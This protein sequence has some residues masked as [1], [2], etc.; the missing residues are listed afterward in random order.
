[1]SHKPVD[2]CYH[3]ETHRLAWIEKQG[4]VSNVMSTQIGEHPSALIQYQTPRADFD[5]LLFSKEGKYLLATK[6]TNIQVWETETGKSL[7][8][9]ND[10]IIQ[11]V[12]AE[13]GMLILGV[14]RPQERH[15]L[16]FR[17]LNTPSA[18]PIEYPGMFFPAHLSLSPDGS[19][20]AFATGGGGIELYHTDGS[21]IKSFQA[22]LN[23]AASVTFSPDGTRLATT[24]G[25]KE[26]LKIWNVETTQELL[27]LKGTGSYLGK[28]Y[29]TEDGKSILVGDPYQSWTAPD[30]KDIQQSKIRKQLEGIPQ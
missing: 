24:F 10:E 5:Q 4:Q 1:M 15:V 29:W 11:M 27:T 26:A 13:G 30:W 3:E 12:F 23:A 16:Q 25:G 18:D 6:A 17:N 28:V 20:V 2:A 7:S 21:F 9:W 14:L 8:E 22:H 19:T